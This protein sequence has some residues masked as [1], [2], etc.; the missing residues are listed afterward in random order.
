MPCITTITIVHI[1]GDE[2][3]DVALFI[4]KSDSTT[5][6]PTG[7]ITFTEH[8]VDKVDIHTYILGLNQV[9]SSSSHFV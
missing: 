2:L 3:C 6:A 5:E 7:F 8:Q 9:R 1:S 4:F